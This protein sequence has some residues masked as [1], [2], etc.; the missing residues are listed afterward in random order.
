MYSK[1]AFVG[2]SDTLGTLAR[3]KARS[4]RNADD[5]EDD[6]YNEEDARASRA[7][8][9]AIEKQPPAAALAKLPA[10]WR[11]KDLVLDGPRNTK[12]LGGRLYISP[13]GMVSRTFEVAR[14]MSRTE[15]TQCRWKYDFKNAMSWL[16]A[17]ATASREALKGNVDVVFPK[18][19]IALQRR[20]AAIKPKSRSGTRM[21]GKKRQRK[22]EGDGGRKEIV[23]GSGGPESRDE[24]ALKRQA[25]GTPASEVH[26]SE[27]PASGEK[28]NV[29]NSNNAAK[30]PLPRKKSRKASTPEKIPSAPAG[31][32]PM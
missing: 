1:A 2:H 16:K 12:V 5:Y 15:K 21:P 19:L 7:A 24:R 30:P 10:G 27:K 4:S 17:Q 28:K 26:V 6:E 9:E 20:K 8:N 18:Y 32:G 23:N 11:V 29:E 25:T 31:A 14:A 22:Q 3:R 13:S